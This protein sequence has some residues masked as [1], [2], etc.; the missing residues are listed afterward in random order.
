MKVI[1]DFFS[2]SDLQ[3]VQDLFYPDLSE[4]PSDIRTDLGRGWV[5]RG[6]LERSIPWTFV[7]VNHP[8][9][10]EGGEYMF[11]FSNMLYH[12]TTGSIGV[13]LSKLSPAPRFL[14]P[15][16]FSKIKSSS[17]LRIKANL[18]LKTNEIETSPFHTDYPLV[19]EFDGLKTSIFYINSN[20]GYTEFEDGTKVESVANRLVTF[21]HHMKHRGTTCTN[22]PFRLVI[23]FNYL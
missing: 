7:L 23:N 11:Q 5:S 8:S 14:I 19:D 13:N 9:L 4:H 18:Q 17:I 21:P 22:Q 15:L 10:F 6:L 1:D 3:R 12:Q 16:F 2:S 20:D